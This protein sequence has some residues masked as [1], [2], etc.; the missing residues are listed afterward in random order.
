MDSL[1]PEKSDTIE[2][3]VPTKKSYLV[4]F[5]IL[6]LSGFA[7]IF[8]GDSMIKVFFGNVNSLFLAIG[9][10]VIVIAIMYGVNVIVSL[11]LQASVEWNAR[12]S[13]V[14]DTRRPSYQ[15]NHKK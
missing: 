1:K 11:G 2:N 6:I 10:Y 13:R 7:G 14:T 4:A 15:L 12:S 8:I 3:L 9:T 5:L